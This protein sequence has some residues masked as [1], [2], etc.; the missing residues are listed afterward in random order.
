MMGS[1]YPHT[2]RLIDGRVIRNVTVHHHLG[3][4]YYRVSWVDVRPK[5]CVAILGEAD[6][7]SEAS[8]DEMRAEMP[9]TQ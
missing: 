8:R 6:E 5:G 9:R 3:K 4:G 7:F 1:P 2:I